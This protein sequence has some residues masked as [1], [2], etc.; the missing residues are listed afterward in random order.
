MV[1]HLFMQ[2]SVAIKPVGACDIKIVLLNVVAAQPDRL[3]LFCEDID[4]MVIDLVPALVV[5]GN[6]NFAGSSSRPFCAELVSVGGVRFELASRA[7][8]QIAE[9]M[10]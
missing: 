3:T 6:G 5:P 7:L 1:R 2:A 8:S 9:G 10:A 4:D